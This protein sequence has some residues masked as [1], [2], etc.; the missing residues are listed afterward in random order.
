VQ[1][2]FGIE[3]KVLGEITDR[4]S[5]VVGDEADDSLFAVA[6]P[7]ACVCASRARAPSSRTPHRSRWRGGWTTL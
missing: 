2:L 5:R 4:A 3:V 7:A 6:L 1:D